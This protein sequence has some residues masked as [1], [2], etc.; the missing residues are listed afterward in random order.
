MSEDQGSSNFLLMLDWPTRKR[1]REDVIV[2]YAAEKRLL[3]FYGWMFSAP[4]IRWLLPSQHTRTPG[5]GAWAILKS[6]HPLSFEVL[7]ASQREEIG[8]LQ[9]RFFTPRR[10]T[11]SVVAG[12]L[13]RI[14]RIMASLTLSDTSEESLTPRIAPRWLWAMLHYGGGCIRPPDRA[15]PQQEH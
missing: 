12:N 9:R 2:Q 13:H 3:D 1:K 4:L 8:P 6:G 14:R 15:N 10:R 7:P 11:R 5:P